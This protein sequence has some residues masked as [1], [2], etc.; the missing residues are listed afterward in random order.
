MLRSVIENYCIFASRVKWMRCD[1]FATS[2]STLFDCVAVYLA[3]AEDLLEIET[4]SFAIT[5]DGFTR[6]S[7]NGPLKARVAMR[8]KDLR[9]FKD[10]L[11]TQLLAKP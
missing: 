10:Q 4:V 9:A 6:R 1:F 8:W 3:G 11:A 2:S 7:A 5:D